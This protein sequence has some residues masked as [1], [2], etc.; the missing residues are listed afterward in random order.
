MSYNSLPRTSLHWSL[1]TELFPFAG[2]YRGL[3][4]LHKL[5]T[6]FGQCFLSCQDALKADAI[7]LERRH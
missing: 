1:T 7:Q 4:I 2:H 3:M 5:H 6:A